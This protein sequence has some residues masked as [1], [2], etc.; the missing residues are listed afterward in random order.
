[1]SGCDDKRCPVHGNIS[2]RGNVFTGTVVSA[3]PDKTVTVERKIVQYV[4]KYERYKKIKSRIYAHN[5]GCIDAKENDVVRVGETRRLSKTKN[6]VVMEIIGKK[7]IVKGEE[8]PIERKKKEG[9]ET[10]KEE[11]KGK[12]VKG[13]KIIE[14]EGGKKGVE[15]ETGEGEGKIGNEKIKEEKKI[16]ERET[17]E[18]EGRKNKEEAGE[19][20]EESTR[21]KEEGKEKGEKAGKEGAEAK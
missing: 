20:E 12:E 11:E 17:G 5:P 6:F 10:E 7:K 8:G 16:I 13:E 1:M 21:E 19:K 9:K 18:G 2:V 4:P 15:G 14:K 3:K